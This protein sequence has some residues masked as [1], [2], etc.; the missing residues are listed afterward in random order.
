[1]SVKQVRVE[2]EMREVRA[3][4]RAATIDPMW[5]GEVYADGNSVKG[6]Y[7]EGCLPRAEVLVR[8]ESHWDACLV[9]LAYGKGEQ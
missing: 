6:R 5:K 2:R 3:A 9:I 1:M 8:C 7:P 4:E